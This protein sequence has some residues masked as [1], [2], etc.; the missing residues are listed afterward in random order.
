MLKKGAVVRISQTWRYVT[1]LHTESRLISGTNFDSKSSANW[2][3]RNVLCSWWRQ[4]YSTPLQPLQD[5]FEDGVQHGV[6]L[7]LLALTARQNEVPVDPRVQR[8]FGVGVINAR[9]EVP[10]TRAA[11][12]HTSDDAHLRKK[13]CREIHL[14]H[15]EREWH[16]RE[17]RSRRSPIS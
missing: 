11:R 7:S 14:E 17:K 3:R 2:E 10:T 1:Q 15:A 13:S 9:C 5:G 16:T 4:L 6:V 12:F 8:A